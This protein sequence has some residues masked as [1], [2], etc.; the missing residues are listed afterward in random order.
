MLLVPQFPHLHALRLKVALLPW[1]SFIDCPHGVQGFF[2]SVFLLLFRFLL[3][4][5]IWLWVSTESE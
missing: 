3:L 1:T 5:V 4:P 2:L